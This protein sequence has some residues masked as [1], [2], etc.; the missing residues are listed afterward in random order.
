[1]KKQGLMREFAAVLLLMATVTGMF[2]LYSALQE[3]RDAVIWNVNEC[4]PDVRRIG[5][6]L[7]SW[8]ADRAYA[9]GE[10]QESFTDRQRGSTS[11]R[12]RIPVY[13][14]LFAAVLSLPG[15]AGRA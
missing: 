3:Q 5:R 10:R 11:V 6:Q 9:D 13:E 14:S 8:P 15:K 1:M 7:P 4:C 12:I 2:R